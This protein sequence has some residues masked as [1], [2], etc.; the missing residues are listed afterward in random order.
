MILLLKV[1]DFYSFCCIDT[2]T[3]KRPFRSCRRRGFASLRR[4]DYV[5]E[6][7]GRK[8]HCGLQL[9]LSDFCAEVGE[10]LLKL[11]KEVA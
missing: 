9:S 5:W 3:S 8:K 6:E 1:W 10:G 7:K 2:T 11:E 4:R